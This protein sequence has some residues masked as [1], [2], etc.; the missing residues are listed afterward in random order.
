MIP[1]DD[2]KN[3]RLIISEIILET[4]KALN[5]SYP[6]TSSERQLELQ[7]FRKRLEK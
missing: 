1:A 2:K 4:F 6:E 5:M 7:S 3:T